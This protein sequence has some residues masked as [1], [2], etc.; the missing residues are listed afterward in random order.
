LHLQKL[1][2]TQKIVNYGICLNALTYALGALA[3]GYLCTKIDRRRVICTGAL[4]SA[5]ALFLIGPS[6]LFHLPNSLVLMFGGLGLIGLSHACV[7][8]P[9]MAEMIK[10]VEE[11]EYHIYQKASG[12]EDSSSSEDEE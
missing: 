6:A 1:G 4:L 10:A 3:A 7:S 8:V 9:T 11:E 5:I 12:E 2:Q